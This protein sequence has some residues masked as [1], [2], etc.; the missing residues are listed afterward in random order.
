[1][2][3]TSEPPVRLSASPHCSKLAAKST[4]VP[5]S[6]AISSI[7]KSAKSRLLPRPFPDRLKPNSSESLNGKRRA[8]R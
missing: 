5:S 1:M 6:Y 2:R 8:P 3:P 4:S 7:V